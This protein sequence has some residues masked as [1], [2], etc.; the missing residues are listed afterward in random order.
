MDVYRDRVEYWLARGMIYIVIGLLAAACQQGD[1]QQSAGPP[2]APPVSVAEVIEREVAEW[3]EFTGRLE[4]VESVEIRPRV[5]GQI[6]R[7][8]YRQGAEV[9]KGDLL[10]VIDAR[11]YKAE[12][13]RARAESERSR[14]QLEL[15]RAQLAR[16]QRVVGE[17]G[18]SKQELDDRASAVK[19]G[20][21]QLAAAVAAVEAARLNVEFTE[22]RAPITGRTGRAEVT[23]GNLVA[24]GTSLLTSIVSLDPIYLYF[25][26][27]E[28]VYLRYRNLARGGARSSS[29]EAPNPVFIGLADEQGHPHQGTIDFI[30]NR[31]DPRTGTI[32]ARAVFANKERRFTPGLFARVKLVGSGRYR[33]LLI[34]DRAIGTD[35]SQKFVLVVG[36]DGKT[37][38]RPVKL[39]PLVDGLRVV[40]EGLKAGEVIVVNGL[41]RVRPGMPVK[42]NKVPM[43]GDAPA[44]AQGK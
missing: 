44:P 7:V 22:V 25:E 4:A 38:Y 14:T 6:E 3:E 35:Q 8:A 31:L 34:N 19:Q 2:G 18:V 30:D 27:D 16:A 23:A 43:Q 5:A 24:P 17:G 1:A 20:E 39:G 12:Y 26:G 9:K 37:Q 28:Q 42:P 40:R 21:A 10:F 15:A 41:Q 13:D 11:P 32:R 29:P 33:A 36:E